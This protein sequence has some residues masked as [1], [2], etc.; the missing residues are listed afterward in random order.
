MKSLVSFFFLINGGRKAR[1]RE[2]GR[3]TDRQT[4]RD[5]GRE[6]WLRKKERLEKVGVGM[7]EG[8]FFSSVT[9]TFSPVE[10][11]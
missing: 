2:R 8:A 6:R 1:Q 3:Q 11:V 5:R 9:T 4:D 7:R 10:N